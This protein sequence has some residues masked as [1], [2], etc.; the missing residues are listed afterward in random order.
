MVS[1]YYI[2]I[3]NEYVPTSKGLIDS[4]EYVIYLYNLKK[5]EIPI[6]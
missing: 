2:F 3:R 1:G 4:E 6:N 5:E